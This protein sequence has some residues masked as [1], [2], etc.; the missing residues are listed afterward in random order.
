M[1]AVSAACL[2]LAAPAHAVLVTFSGSSIANNTLLGAGAHGGSFDWSEVLRPDLQINSASY[3]FTF[4]DNIDVLTT[5]SRVFTE[6]QETPFRVHQ[7]YGGGSSDQYTIYE[8]NST[9]VYTRTDS[10]VGEGATV[11]L[12]N[13]SVA[14]G[15]GATSTTSTVMTGAYSSYVGSSSYTTGTPGQSYSYTCG[16]TPLHPGRCSG[17]NGGSYYTYTT[18]N[19]VTERVIVNDQTGTF[20][21]SGSITDPA[22]FA[23][24]RAHQALTFS[25]GVWG[26]LTLSSASLTLDVSKAV[27][28][29]PEPGTLASVGAGLAVMLGLAR[30]R[31]VHGAGRLA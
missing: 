15:A 25:L 21:V 9:D 17:Y 30:R 1:L 23:E 26:D 27:A 5:G 8:R 12:G 13:A 4:A 31:R 14:A 11:T 2:L 24:M 7:Q 29:V 28:P 3:S 10:R 18:I 6:T 16:G 19:L 22:L 20:T